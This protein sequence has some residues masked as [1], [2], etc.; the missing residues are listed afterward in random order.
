M[1]AESRAKNG[2]M[3]RGN[4]AAREAR[5]AALEAVKIARTNAKN[6]GG[7]GTIKIPEILYG[8]GIASDRTKSKGVVFDLSKYNTFYAQLG[9]STKKFEGRHWTAPGRRDWINLVGAQDGQRFSI[10]LVGNINAS[11]HQT[12]GPPNWRGAPA[13]VGSDRILLRFSNSNATLD[14]D[15]I[16]TKGG[17]GDGNLYYKDMRLKYR[18][19]EDA[20]S[21][22]SGVYEQINR[23]SHY[24]FRV[25]KDMNGSFLCKQ[26]D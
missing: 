21:K 6:L 3:R 5:A 17:S 20:E 14:S 12:A 2:A 18:M 13:D 4:Q 11:S 19:N 10:I 7:V 23:P 9:T 1:T 15:G 8:N 25:L 26:E 22:G 16:P 24:K